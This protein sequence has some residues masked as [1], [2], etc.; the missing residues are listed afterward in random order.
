[1]RN[2][3]V[4]KASPTICQVGLAFFVFGKKVEN[5][6]SNSLAKDLTIFGNL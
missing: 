6:T 3:F 4:V 1:M 2:K 5:T